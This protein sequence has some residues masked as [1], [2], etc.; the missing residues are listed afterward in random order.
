M[1][2]GTTIKPESAHWGKYKSEVETFGFNTIIITGP[3]QG[4][5]GLRYGRLVQVRKKSGAF[6]SDTVLLREPDGRLMSY[7]NMGFFAVSSD[8]V[9][10]YEKSMAGVELDTPNRSYNIQGNNSAQGFIVEGL[11]DTNGKLYSLAIT[12][13]KDKVTIR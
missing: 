10:E 1:K 13:E 7:H 6:G 3:I 4:Q 8:F 11:D 5:S 2:K 9:E 12:V